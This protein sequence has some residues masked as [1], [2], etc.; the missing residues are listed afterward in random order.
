MCS[1]PDSIR[2]EPEAYRKRLIIRE[3]LGLQVHLPWRNRKGV[4]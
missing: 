4:V 3:L 2:S 1:K